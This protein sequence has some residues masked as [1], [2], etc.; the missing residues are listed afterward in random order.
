MIEVKAECSS[1]DVELRAGEGDVDSRGGTQPP[2]A[3]GALRLTPWSPL[4]QFMYPSHTLYQL[5]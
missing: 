5:G 3:Y 1:P 4:S 2:D